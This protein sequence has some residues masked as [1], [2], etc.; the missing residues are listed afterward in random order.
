MPD[1]RRF[2]SM[3]PDLSAWGPP[4]FQR[5]GHIALIC[6]N[7][8]GAVLSR[9]VKERFPSAQLWGSKEFFPGV[10]IYGNELKDFFRKI[11]PTHAGIVLFGAAGIAVRSAAPYIT[12]KL[13]DPALVAVDD[14]GG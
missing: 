1:N 7:E 13:S 11:W 2:P 3:C 5:P 4:R 6:V 9:R 8:E 10:G 14:S 12:S